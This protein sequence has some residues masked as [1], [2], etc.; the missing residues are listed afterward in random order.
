[1]LNYSLRFKQNV[2]SFQ[3]LLFQKKNLFQNNIPEIF[4]LER[5]VFRPMIST[6]QFW[7]QFHFFH[8]ALLQ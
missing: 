3:S 1:M 8:A 6:V 5:N 7:T 2:F 4:I